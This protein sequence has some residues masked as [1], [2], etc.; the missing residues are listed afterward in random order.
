MLCFPP[1]WLLSLL[2]PYFFEF[3]AKQFWPSESGCL[4]VALEDEYLNLFS[5]DT[6]AQ[7]AELLINIC[8]T[9]IF[10]H[11]SSRRDLAVYEELLLNLWITLAYE[12]FKTEKC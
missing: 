7:Y 9:A 2:F 8:I 10:V 11:T 3:D 1:Q 4:C 12:F 6:L 5:W